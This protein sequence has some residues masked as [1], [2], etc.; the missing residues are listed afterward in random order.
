MADALGST[1]ASPRAA[2]IDGL[3][4]I[5]GLSTAAIAGVFLHLQEIG[6]LPQC[7]RIVVAVAVGLF[8]ISIFSGVNYL[9][10]L[11][12]VDVVKERNKEIDTELA[13][14]TLDEPQKDL[15]K[16]EKG[17]RLKRINKSKKVNPYWHKGHLIAFSIAALL[18]AVI[19]CF[20]VLKAA[21][22]VEKKD[23]ANKGGVNKDPEKGVPADF[24]RYDIV[25]SATHKYGSG[26]EAHTFLLDR[27][28]GDLWQMICQPK[29]TVAFSRVKKI[30]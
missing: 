16:T 2:Y 26:M 18:S 12:T 15:L 21:S 5:I 7:P 23:D 4:W 20:A 30:D 10:W 13:D 14:T 8:F 11:T 25:Y 29:G 6:R 19:L 9:V 3:K 28:T 17:K 1:P 24:A 27:R 22:S